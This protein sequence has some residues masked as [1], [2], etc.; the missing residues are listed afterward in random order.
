MKDANYAA[1]LAIRTRVLGPAHVARALEAATDFDREW[2]R[3]VTSHAWG[4]VWT[5]R[6]LEARTRSLLT[7]AILAALGRE[8]ELRLHVRATRNTGATRVEVKETL[9]HLAVYAGV[10]AANAAFR[11]AKA[12]FAEMA[13]EPPVRARATPA[14]RKRR[15]PKR[16]AR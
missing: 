9:L 1:G 4:A 10:P 6:G 2:Q 7:I 11:I 5:R 16:G 13:A 8:E 12:A 14:A 15:T 3:F